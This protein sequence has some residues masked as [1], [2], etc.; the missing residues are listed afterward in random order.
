MLTEL[1]TTAELFSKDRVLTIPSRLLFMSVRSPKR[2]KPSVSITRLIL[3]EI[4]FNHLR[5][6]AAVVIFA[7]I[8]G[9]S[10]VVTRSIIP[11]CNTTNEPPRSGQDVPTFCSDLG[12]LCRSSLVLCDSEARG[13]FTNLRRAVI[14]FLQREGNFILLR[15]LR[16]PL[17]AISFRGRNRCHS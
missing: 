14:K 7:F 10:L 9:L 4:L 1:P 13:G 15:L 5:L 3:V 17:L 2:E 12:S 8:S 11:F 6:F 16:T